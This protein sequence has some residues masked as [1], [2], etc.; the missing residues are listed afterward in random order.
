MARHKWGP[1]ESMWNGQDVE[2]CAHCDTERTRDTS[3]ASLYL[4]RRGKAI[5]PNRKPMPE[6]WA[7]YKAGV[8]P[9]CVAAPK[10][11]G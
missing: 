5:Q 7:A 1:T 9:K 6:E 3:T 4:F 11:G 8:I 10:C 2:R